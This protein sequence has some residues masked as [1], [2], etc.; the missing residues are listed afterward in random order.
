MGAGTR[1][2]PSTGAIKMTTDIGSRQIT[3]RIVL[4]CFGVVATVNAIMV[5]AAVS[6]FAGTQTDSAYRA[7][8]T[9]KNEEAAAAAQA[10]LNW[11]VTGQMTRATS[12]AAVLTVHVSDV[13]GVAI[14]GIDVTAYLAHPL[15]ARLDRV[16]RLARQSDG[17]YRGETDAAA[18]Q[19]ELKLQAQ[20]NGERVYRS[21]TRVM[22]K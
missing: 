5:R 13:R 10:A 2:F 14:G 16:V 11:T 3:G 1:P 22:F 20:R 4:F 18:G 9:Y 19:W 12:G 17:R 21:E 15:N 8:L 7:G 6:T